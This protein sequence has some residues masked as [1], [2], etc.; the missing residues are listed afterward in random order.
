M[1][2]CNDCRGLVEDYLSGSLGESKKAVFEDHLARCPGCVRELA[3]MRKLDDALRS[4][5]LKA[6][7]A[8]F[9]SRTLARLGTEKTPAEGDALLL[10]TLGYAASAAALLF[11]V[12]QWFGQTGWM[13]LPENAIRAFS[14]YLPVEAYLLLSESWDIKSIFS[15][16]PFQRMVAL[17]DLFGAWFS[18]L[19]ALVD[20]GLLQVGLLGGLFTVTWILSLLF[21]NR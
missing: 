7:P 11:G 14:R 15:L 4:R 5:R 19:P 18:T 6:P 3:A 12:G 16:E 10:Q 13:S 9:T 17:S 8:D 20:I 1:T 2:N 21:S